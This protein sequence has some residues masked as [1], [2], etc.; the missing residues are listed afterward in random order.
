MDLLTPTD[1]VVRTCLQPL[2][3]WST[4]RCKSMCN[5]RQRP[6][7]LVDL[8]S[9]IA[10]PTAP[11]IEWSTWT[12]IEDSRNNLTSVRPCFSSRPRPR[13]RRSLGHWNRWNPEIQVCYDL[14]GA[15]I[16]IISAEISHAQW[17]NP[18]EGPLRNWHPRGSF[19][20]QSF[21]CSFRFY[22]TQK[23]YKRSRTNS[24]V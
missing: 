21:E 14:K 10:Q 1:I 16:Q 7:R 24:V 8:T 12:R 15:K 19:P 13:S 4:S 6:P 5:P 20:T 22:P 2:F 18:T 17:F 23:S 9:L 11:I 3:E